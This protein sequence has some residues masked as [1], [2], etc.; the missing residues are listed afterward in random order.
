MVKPRELWMGFF[1]T[2]SVSIYFT[3]LSPSTAISAYLLLC[4]CFGFAVAAARLGHANTAV[5][6]SVL[7][8]AFVV[9]IVADPLEIGLYGHDSYYTLRAAR[10][11]PGMDFREFIASEAAFPG[12]YALVN[13]ISEVTGLPLAVI[14][15]YWG[16]SSAFFSLFFY[17]ILRN[18]LGKKW[19]AFA[20]VGIASIQ[21]LLFFEAKFVDEQVAIMLFPI[22]LFGAFDTRRRIRALSLVA[23][24]TIAVVHHASVL[25]IGTIVI[26]I[27]LFQALPLPPLPRLSEFSDHP[28]QEVA[29]F[30]FLIAAI[31]IS[32]FLHLAPSFTAMLSRGILVVE[33][34]QQTDTG[35]IGGSVDSLAATVSSLGGRAAT[36]ALGVIA[37]VSVF[38]T[39][40]SHWEFSWAIVG[41]II[42]GL[43]VVLIGIGNPT[44]L[45]PIRMYV[46]FVP[47]LLG[48]AA[49]VAR[50]N[51]GYARTLITAVLAAFI[52]T[53]VFAIAPHALLTTPE[54]GNID[55]G[56]Y[57]SGE[58]AAAEWVGS[59]GT[60]SVLGYEMELWEVIGGT[61]ANGVDELSCPGRFKSFRDEVPD[62]SKM[63]SD[64]YYSSGDTAV[65]RCRP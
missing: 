29:T 9:F 5:S 27:I 60:D 46:F 14:G 11:F 21:T 24:A 6:L 37:L 19:A 35:S 63:I 43:F 31:M 22:V 59:H 23:F 51:S 8:T 65:G 30:P 48:V 41:G 36:A 62:A 28:L 7:S 54:S 10:E 44:N 1:L 55:G 34:N 61:Q 45:A 20:A 25:I 38:S 33:G 13:V 3:I 39:Q 15:K 56:H 40:K 57:T 17:A 18:H 2:A 49:A 64:I 32:S 42:L 50:R 53:Q 52:V 26:G 4:L 16:L 58:V 47:L 12:F